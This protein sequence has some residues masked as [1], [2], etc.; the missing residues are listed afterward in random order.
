MCPVGLLD[1]DC[2]ELFNHN[3]LGN[4]YDDNNEESEIDY[5]FEI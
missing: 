5:E 4:K 2:C 1:F 3:N